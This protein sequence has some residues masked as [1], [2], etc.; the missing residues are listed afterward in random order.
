MTIQNPGKKRKGK[1]NVE[2][3]GSWIKDKIINSNCKEATCYF[4]VYM[5]FETSSWGV[6]RGEQKGLKP[7]FKY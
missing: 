4:Y 7:L 2:K 6:V 5:F 3:K 1:M